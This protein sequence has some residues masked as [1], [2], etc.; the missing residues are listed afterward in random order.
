[1]LGKK[2]FL[3]LLISFMVS[4]SASYVFATSTI[5]ASFDLYEINDDEIKLAENIDWDADTILKNKNKWHTATVYAKVTAEYID[6]GDNVSPILMILQSNNQGSKP[7]DQAYKATNP[8]TGQSMYGKK[9][10]DGEG[11]DL[12]S[13]LVKENSG[14]GANNFIPM[15]WHISNFVYS[16]DASFSIFSNPETDAQTRYLIDEWDSIIPRDSDTEEMLEIS[17]ALMNYVTIRDKN[18]FIYTD[19]DPTEYTTQEQADQ[20]CHILEN[21]TDNT[22][23]IYFGG[24]FANAQ[25]GASFGTT[26]ILIQV[27]PE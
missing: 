9:G 4:T 2:I 16:K 17:P 26:R 13:G 5:N 20:H 11:Y 6:D 8:R 24:Q 7:E 18:G 21:V 12:Y 14:G 25:P 19:G 1:M 15:A 3:L 23:Y 27:I 22:A 10:D